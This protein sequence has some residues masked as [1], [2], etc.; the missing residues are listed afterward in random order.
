MNFSNVKQIFINEKEPR[1]PSEYQE[2]EYIE[3]TGT[4]YI[5]TDLKVYR[6]D[7]IETEFSMTDRDEKTDKYAISTQPWNNDGASRFAMGV[8]NYHYGDGCWTCGFGVYATD[9]TYLTPV[10]ESD[11]NFHTW[12]YH[13]ADFKI[14]DLNVEWD[15]TNDTNIYS[16]DSI[17]SN[18]VYLFYGYNGC[19]KSRIKYYRQ[20]RSGE[21]IANFIPCYRKS[22]DEIGMYDLV[23][24]SFFTN[25]GTGTFS[26][27]SD[28]DTIIEVT[29]EVKQISQG[30]DFKSIP[31]E[32]QEVDY[33]E[34]TGTQYINTGV[35]GV[36]TYG[37][38]LEFAPETITHNTYPSILS[39]YLD[40]ATLG[41]FQDSYKMYLRIQSVEIGAPFYSGF[42]DD[43]WY[44]FRMTNSSFEV[45]NSSGTVVYQ[46]TA[47][48]RPW[49]AYSHTISVFNAYNNPQDRISCGKLKSL[50]LYDQD[51]GKLVDFVPCYR[52]LD[53]VIGLYDRVS[54]T[55]FTNQGTGTFTK[56]PDTAYQFV[57]YIES[58]GTQ[59]IDTEISL[60]DY[61]QNLDITVDAY[62]G[63]NPY[64]TQG[65][66]YSDVS[67]Q[68]WF[69]F[70][71]IGNS[72]AYVQCSKGIYA[73]FNKPNSRIKVS[74]NSKTAEVSL[75]GQTATT[76]S[77]SFITAASQ[78]S[79]SSNG[80]LYLFAAHDWYDDSAK[81]GF[82]G[83]KLY[84]CIIKNATTGEL[85]RN[86]HPCYRISDNEIGLYDSVSGRFFSNGGTG[87]FT[88]G[89][90]IP[91]KLVLWERSSH[92]LPAGYTELE[93]IESSGTQYIDTGVSLRDYDQ[94]LFITLDTYFES[95]PT[96]VG[97]QG[98]NYSGASGYYWHSFPEQDTSSYY[99]Q[100][101]AG[102]WSTF[103]S[104]YGSRVTITSNSKTAKFTIGD[105]TMTSG[106]S[107]F[108]NAATA[109]G[110]SNNGNLYLF[111]ANDWYT[112]S[113]ADFMY[114]ERIYSCTF[115]NATTEELIR[116]FVPCLR[117]SDG[118]IGLY[119]Y[120]TGTFFTNQGTGEFIGHHTTSIVTEQIS[121]L[122]L[123]VS[124][125]AIDPFTESV[126][127]PVSDDILS[128]T[129]T[130]SIS[131]V[132]LGSSSVSV[133]EVSDSVSIDF[134]VEE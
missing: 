132:S 13:D 49:S 96:A 125:I 12:E 29:K 112:D 104:V 43:E 38:S 114:G 77:T 3:G 5:V 85:L 26:K 94:N 45:I 17:I 14:V 51:N 117:E 55:F 78:M 8:H 119:D 79:S 65:L 24:N 71:E 134:D 116:D 36:D 16:V 68:Y 11:T 76:S 127:S 31:D 105:Q 72:K 69:S 63:S 93:Y 42:V 1:L 30:V 52:K 60:R 129:V 113:A 64:G 22:D 130:E 83:E 106:S 66:E 23:S 133:E 41:Y 54:G 81:E 123:N 20:Y 61:D 89:S 34:G 18:K 53:S 95:S 131:D 84:S 124:P 70:P 37:F 19:T 110:S 74:I 120:V 57:E 27:G 56:G 58:S 44:T 99:M 91:T 98:L 15:H 108:I 25:A 100:C 46:S 97:T 9:Q 33:I 122:I 28:H 4:Q 115:S 88:K 10:T 92:I 102:S 21:C 6:T 73:T 32:Y 101:S 7:S 90:N 107:S 103:T 35:R 75:G 59:F 47:R 62:Y 87:V 48:T 126:S 128:E 111:A 82:N 39:G 67:N 109:A 86:F 2:V 118:E 50:V 80:N 121:N 40:E